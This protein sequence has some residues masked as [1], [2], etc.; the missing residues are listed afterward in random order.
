MPPLHNLTTV[1][2]LQYTV[3]IQATPLDLK[4]VERG[5]YGARVVAT[6]D[7]GG[8]LETNEFAR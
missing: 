3:P 1:H 4:T 6:R 8:Y 2:G 7:A 5:R